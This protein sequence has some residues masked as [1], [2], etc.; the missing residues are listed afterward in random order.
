[1]PTSPSSQRWVWCLASVCWAGL[2]QAQPQSAS[3]AAP[4]C[5]VAID[6]GHSVQQPGATS[7]RGVGEFH[8]NQRMA[9]VLRA[10]INQRPGTLAF[11]IN[12]GGDSIALTA[13][14][15]AALAQHADL[16]LS[17]HHDSLQPR[18][19]SSWT[20]SGQRRPYSDR[21]RGHSLFYSNLNPR[22]DTSLAVAQRIGSHLRAAGFTPT[23]HH[24][25]AIDGERRV[26][27]DPA[28][29][30][31]VFDELV[32]LKTATMPAVLLECGVILHRD[33]ELL[34]ADPAY[35]QRLA[36]AVADAVEEACRP[37]A[38]LRLP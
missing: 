20:H 14:T 25:E 24:A 15:D 3:A 6:V 35:Q 11:L 29:G 28:L 1:M 37:G 38:G 4:V 23:L 22:A 13:R 12:E 30:V 10:V 16:L 7:A 31:Y 5:R 21:F 34:L 8:F 18:Y 2:A 26:L 27:A 19:L 17:V 32:V 33:E 9:R 36:K